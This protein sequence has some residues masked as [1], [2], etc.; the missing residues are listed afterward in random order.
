MEVRLYFRPMNPTL[1]AIGAGA[2]FGLWSLVM[3]LTGL[4][5]GGVAF[6]LMAGTLLVTAPWFLLVRPE[7]FLAAGRNVPVALL[8]GLGAACLN[9]VGMVLLPPLLEAPPGAVGTRILILNL[10]VVGVTALWSVTL[11]GHSLSVS[12]VSGMLL[13]IL[14]V[15]LL[16]K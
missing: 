15:W 6:M 5:G 14:A 11:G 7:P 16:S 12:K 4:R 2:G 3:S 9:G 8:V 1:A 10:T 13:A